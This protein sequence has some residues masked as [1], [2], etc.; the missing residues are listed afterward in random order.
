[1]RLAPQQRVSVHA[2]EDASSALQRRPPRPQE[3]MTEPDD[4]P[5]R[6]EPPPAPDLRR[7]VRL[8]TAQWIGIPVLMLVPLLAL[9]G[10]FGENR[11]RLEAA[12]DGLDTT[13]DYPTRLRTGQRTHIELHVHNRSDLPA[14]DVTVRFEPRYFEHAFNLLFIPVPDAPYEVKLPALAPGAAGRVR[15]EFELEQ[16][17]RNTGGIS[18]FRDGQ[19]TAHTRISTFILP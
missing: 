9:L 2:L 18:V 6:A 5:D 13:V 3:H 8:Y 11:A 15:V 4:P 19:D 1:M 17:W 12:R 7:H 14:E 10:L 16:R